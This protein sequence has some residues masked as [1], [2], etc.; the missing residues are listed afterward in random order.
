MKNVSIIDAPPDRG[1]RA[2]SVPRAVKSH[3][4]VYQ[5]EEPLKEIKYDIGFNCI[6]PVSVKEKRFRMCIDTGAGRS[7]IQKEFREKLSKNAQTK[8]GVIERRK[9]RGDVHCTGI[10]AGMSSTK[11]EHEAVLELT[12]DPVSEDGSKPPPRTGLVLEMGE[13]VGA[14]DHLLMGFPDIVRLDVRF[15]DDPDGNV[16]VTFNSLGVTVLAETPPRTGS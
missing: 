2:T 4:G 8:K 12:L 14:S 16:W 5:Y 6:I 7:M 11:M 1:A 15:F 10:C 9:I 13:L 3:Q